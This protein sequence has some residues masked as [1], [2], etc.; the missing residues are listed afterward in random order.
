MSIDL[1]RT[2]DPAR[3]ALRA[4]VAAVDRA[5]PLEQPESLVAAW[6]DLV[7]LLALGPEPAYRECPGCGAVAMREASVCGHCWMELPP[8]AAKLDGPPRDE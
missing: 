2:P 5:I 3:S 7:A 4:A 8:I 6:R 1:T